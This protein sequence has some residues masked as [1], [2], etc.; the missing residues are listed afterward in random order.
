MFK[1]FVM[2]C[3]KRCNQEL[4][5]KEVNSQISKAFADGKV[6]LT[7]KED[8]ADLIRWQVIWEDGQHKDFIREVSKRV[9]A[10][11]NEMRVKR[12]DE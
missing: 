9:V 1:A 10:E 7:V 4:I 3:V 2:K 11:I 6:Y 5:R 8:A 12:G